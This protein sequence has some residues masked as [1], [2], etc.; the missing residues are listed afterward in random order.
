MESLFETAFWLLII[1]IWIVAKVKRGS[2]GGNPVNIFPTPSRETT[3]ED[4]SIAPEDS[5][6][7]APADEIAEFFK[8]LRGEDTPA[9]PAAAIEKAPILEPVEP[10]F[11]APE[12]TAPIKVKEAAP[13]KVHEMEPAEYKPFPGTEELSEIQRAIVLAEILGPPR[14]KRHSRVI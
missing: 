12:E 11:V 13:I 2:R 6:Y 5:S 9:R 14:A 8:G 7:K 4:S 3:P 10:V 1:V